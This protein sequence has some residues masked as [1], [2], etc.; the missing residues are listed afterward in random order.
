MKKNLFY[1]IALAGLCL[2][3]CPRQ[4]QAQ[5]AYGVSAVGYDS[6]TRQIFGYSETYLDYYAAYY[7][8]PAVQGFLF[9][10]YE[11]EI[12]LDQGYDEGYSDPYYGILIPAVVP[13]YSSLYR[14][15]TTY[16]EY[17]NHFVRSYYYYSS[18]YG[19]TSGCFADPYG[20]SYFSGGGGYGNFGFPGFFYDPYYRVSGG[21][22]YLGRT[23][24][25]ITTPDE[26]S[27]GNSST[28]YDASENASIPC[29]TPTPTPTPTNVSVVWRSPSN[30]PAVPISGPLPA[31]PGSLPFVNSMVLTAT[32]SPSGGT[33]SWTTSSNKVR[34]SNITSDGTNSSVTVTSVSKSDSAMDVQIE[35]AY[36]YDGRTARPNPPIKLT[37]QEARSM[38]VVSVDSNGPTTDCRATRTGRGTRGWKKVITWQVQDQF[39]APINFRLPLYDTLVNNANNCI[40]PRA[41]EGTLP[42]RGTGF[43][44]R[45]VHDYRLCSTACLNGRNCSVTGVQHYYVNGYLID[46]NYTMRCDGISVAGDGSSPP[47]SPPAGQMAIADFVDTM[48]VGSLQYQPSDADLQTWTNTLTNAQ[49]QGQAQMLTQARAFERSLFQSAEYASLSRS[50]ED[51]VADLYW[52]YLMREPDE[53][54]YNYWLS[55]LQNDNA[56]G[57]NGRE[58]LLQAFE[59]CQEFQDVLNSLVAS[60]PPSSCDPIQEQSCYDNGGNWNSS[61][62]SCTYPP[63]PCINKPWLCDA[64]Y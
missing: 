58:H 9:W 15:K 10:Q 38:G 62:C 25:T 13:T 8:D 64:T 52:A 41:G 16:E 19:F 42:G 55:V 53:A 54:G 51:F 14:P 1:I 43:D 4:A 45:W 36:T 23:Y 3:L 30:P 47:G 60:T 20:F 39:G 6:Q 34:L 18:C 59:S 56:Q 26:S 22:Y 5:Y 63:D 17:S 11:N 48:W 40:V 57:F 7:Y 29:P 28:F 12:P 35:L 49:A 2:L 50:D 21:R 37:V 32:G 33:F 27:C 46:K 31:P 61:T 44:G 24:V